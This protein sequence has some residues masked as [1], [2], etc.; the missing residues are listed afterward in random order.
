MYGMRWG[1]SRMRKLLYAVILFMVISPFVGHELSGVW[2]DAPNLE[3][4]N[5]T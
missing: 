5:L 4:I 2:C 3:G 1:P